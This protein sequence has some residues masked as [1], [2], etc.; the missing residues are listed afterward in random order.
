MLVFPFLATKLTP[1]LPSQIKMYEED[2]TL[3]L[4]FF[5]GIQAV[6]IFELA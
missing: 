5:H 6:R 2:L 3:S 4:L 1:P